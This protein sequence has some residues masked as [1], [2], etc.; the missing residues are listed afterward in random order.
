MDDISIPTTL[1]FKESP[2]IAALTIG[3]A[4]LAYSQK[5]TAVCIV[6]IVLLLFLMYFYRYYEDNRR[7]P[8]NHIVSPASGTITNIIQSGG[9]YLISIFLSPMDLHTQVYPANSI[10]LKSIYDETGKFGIVTDMHKS[11]DN[12]KVIHYLAMKDGTVLKVTQIAGFLPR[13]IVYDGLP[14]DRVM[15][16]EYLGMIKFGSRVDLMLPMTSVS[17][18]PFVLMKK[19]GDTIGLSDHIGHYKKVENFR[20]DM[21]QAAYNAEPIIGHDGLYKDVLYSNYVKN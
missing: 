7:F 11:R 3:A 20:F 14:G 12:E 9:Y 6:I 17:D 4:I 2:I 16:G 5:E 19:V 10:L 8:D 15:A 21:Q 1:L 13:R 18:T